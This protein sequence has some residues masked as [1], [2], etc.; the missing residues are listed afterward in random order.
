[1]GYPLRNLATRIAT[2]NAY[3][4]HELTKPPGEGPAAHTHPDMEE[5]FYILEGEFTFTVGD[6]Q[7]R[8][9]AGTFLLVPRG[10][11]HHFRNSGDTD[12]RY[13]ALF[14]PAMGE[15]MERGWN[16]RGARAAASRIEDSRTNLA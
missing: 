11:S 12:G 5:A 6:D 14:S 10:A 8:A 16:D 4:L 13:L 9:P 1:M 2:A 7:V 15:A 3:S